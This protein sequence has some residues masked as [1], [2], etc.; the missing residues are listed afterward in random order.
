MSESYVDPTVAGLDGG[1]EKTALGNGTGMS[2]DDWFE[3]HNEKTL[4]RIRKFAKTYDLPKYR[5]VYQGLRESVEMA[6]LQTYHDFDSSYNVKPYTYVERV[7]NFYMLKWKNSDF[8]FR[9]KPFSGNVQLARKMRIANARATEHENATGE[10]LDVSKM[11]IAMKGFGDPNNKSQRGKKP[12]Y[13]K[14]LISRNAI[15]ALSVGCK[16][17]DEL[18]YEDNSGERTTIGDGLVDSN[19]LPEDEA[20]KNLMIEFVMDYM[21]ERYTETEIKF[22]LDWVDDPLR[23]FKKWFGTDSTRGEACRFRLRNKRILNQLRKEFAR[24]W[25]MAKYKVEPRPAHWYKGSA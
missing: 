10:K 2:M 18:V 21:K 12:K 15:I 8:Y 19:P 6:I 25:M 14:N 7:S 4:V 9:N 3:F 17:S 22:L 11:V 1:L 5:W 20:E 24:P 23:V 13:K 16:S